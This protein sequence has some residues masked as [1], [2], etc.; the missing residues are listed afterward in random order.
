[1]GVEGEVSRLYFDALGE[2]LPSEIYSGGRSRR[3]PKDIFNAFLSYGYGVLYSEIER[4]CVV[5]GL[6]P[7]LGFLHADRHGRV[8]LV[9]DLI[10]EFRQAIVDRAMVTL[11]VRRQMSMED[12]DKFGNEFLLNSKGKRKVIETLMQRFNTKVKYGGKKLR[13][14]DIILAQARRITR[15][16]NGDSRRYKPFVHR[17]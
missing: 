4:A 15:F 10:E 9:L 14:R 1:M 8:S 7:Y 11:A 16:L 13:F 3:P 2:V 6:D 17:W 12:A 5:S